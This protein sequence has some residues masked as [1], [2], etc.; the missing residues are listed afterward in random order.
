[1]DKAP[2][3]QFDDPALKAAIARVW[4]GESAPA[5]LRQRIEQI[6]AQGVTDEPR[7]PAI[8]DRVLSWWRNP[9]HGLAAAILILVVGGGWYYY[10]GLSEQ[11][12]HQYSAV[13]ATFASALTDAHQRC[14]K[15]HDH[16]HIQAPRSD[17]QAINQVLQS[18]LNQPVLATSLNDGWVFQGAAICR[19]GGSPAA[20]LTFQ[21]GT[22]TIS[23]FSMPRNACG[24]GSLSGSYQL[25]T[26]DGYHIAGFAR[27]DDLYCVVGYCPQGNLS[28]GEVISMRNQLRDRMK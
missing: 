12:T 5:S 27:H 26:A 18:Q 2:Q 22:Q 6:V 21:R 14:F 16:H 13:P 11:Y 7:G 28:L 9:L 20:H 15:A 17:F 4:A 3:E 25:I 1:M 23:V 24:R 10:Q 19:V 8:R